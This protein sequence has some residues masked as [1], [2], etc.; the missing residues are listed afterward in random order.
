MA[1]KFNFIQ[2]ASIKIFFLFYNYFIEIIMNKYQSNFTLINFIYN[3]YN[4]Y[5]YDHR[6]IINNKS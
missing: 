5:F 1:K 3:Q 2:Y 4:Y 6:I